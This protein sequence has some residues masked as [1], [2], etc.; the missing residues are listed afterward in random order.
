[1]YQLLP[2]SEE[3]FD[4]VLCLCKEYATERNLEWLV[5]ADTWLN[6]LNK[7]CSDDTAYVLLRDSVAIGM[8][9]MVKGPH[10][11][12]H[13]RTIMSPLVIYIKPEYR[14]VSGLLLMLS[15][16]N[17][18]GET[19]DYSY[20]SLPETANLKPSTMKKLG[21]KISEIVYVKETPC[22]QQH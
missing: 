15:Q 8:L 20:I 1:M 22:K 12:N 7:M 9:L 13:T 4:S 11:I 17:L 21:Y 14:N 5:H 19:V 3:T 2:V 10:P 16:F 6:L 18:T